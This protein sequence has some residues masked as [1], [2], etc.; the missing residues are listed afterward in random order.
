MF[1]MV[2]SMHHNKNKKL[3][4]YEMN[5][6]NILAKN[7]E[8][9][10]KYCNKNVIRRVENKYLPDFEEMDLLNTLC[11]RWIKKYTDDYTDDE[12]KDIIKQLKVEFLNEKDYYMLLDKPSTIKFTEL[13]E[14]NSNEDE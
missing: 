1:V 10:K 6:N 7:Y 3:T 12:V 11:I 13:T 9:L 8:S 2:K 14:T 4:H 5:I